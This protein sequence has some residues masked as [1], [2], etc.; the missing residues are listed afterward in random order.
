MGKGV[1]ADEHVFFAPLLSLAWKRKGNG[2][3]LSL[4]GLSGVP[5]RKGAEK[6]TGG[7][8][9]NVW[10][11]LPRGGDRIYFSLLSQQNWQEWRK[12][13]WF[14]WGKEILFAAAVW[15]VE[16]VI[17][18]ET[19]VILARHS[20][21]FVSVVILCPHFFKPPFKIVGFRNE[22]KLQTD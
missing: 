22:T 17:A 11:C 20:Y 8:D 10:G 7:C 6:D 15:R 12:T 1:K 5:R 3:L 16:L 18:K 4:D 2:A 13:L 14:R 9:S 19:I 21:G